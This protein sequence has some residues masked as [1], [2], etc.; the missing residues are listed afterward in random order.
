MTPT[1]TLPA[2][3]SPAGSAQA[4]PG[5]TPTA[6]RP[7][8]LLAHAGRCRSSTQGAVNP[9]V[10]RA[11]TVL[12]DSVA[13]MRS[14]Q[15]GYEGFRYGR[16]G[17][18]TTRQLEQA[19]ATLEG[20]D[21][22]VAVSSGFAAIVTALQAFVR[23]GDHI[24]VSDGVYEP[25]R[26]FC[27]TRLAEQGVEVEFFPPR[28]GAGIAHRLRPQTR[29]VYLEAPSSI[30]FEL[31][32]VPAIVEAVRRGDGERPAPV[33]VVLDNTWATPLFYRPLDLGVDV[34]VQAATKYVVGHA[35]AMLGLV[36]AR[37][38]HFPALRRAAIDGGF[39]ASPDDAYLGL[40]GL[41]TLSVRLERHQRNA[42]AVAA[43]LERRPE[44][45][46][47]LY[48]ALPSHPDHALWRRDFRGASGLF[49]VV[50]KPVPEEQV[51]RFIDSLHL[52][53]IGFCWGGYESL[54]SP[55]PVQAGRDPAALGLNGPLVRL[56]VGLEDPADLIADLE[57]A[58]RHLAPAPAATVG[59][60][61]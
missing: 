5:P 2:P 7:D 24:L 55:E 26:R 8:T 35:D 33:V 37:D 32:D 17:T 56:H 6:L 61:V 41:R 48:P 58:L 57:G 50:L 14:A 9:A 36:A 13:A 15:Q 60:A 47:V 22:A 12:F 31:H 59:G 20:A 30:T 43:W 49:S 45:E 4:V 46:R 44:V 38:A 23:P 19:Y 34:V 52:F 1:A 51:V 54:V 25:A 18:P 28:T 42:L 10:V 3:S 53:G 16:Y 11:S 27:L 39:S 21:G 29:L 40:R